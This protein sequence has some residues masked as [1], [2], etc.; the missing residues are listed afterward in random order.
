MF[1]AL[2]QF[3]LRSCFG[4]VPPRAICPGYSRP[5]KCALRL[6]LVPPRAFIVPGYLRTP[7]CYY[8]AALVITRCRAASTGQRL[9]VLNMSNPADAASP[10]LTP[11]VV[12]ASPPL[13]PQGDVD[14]HHRAV[15]IRI[16]N[17]TMGQKFFTTDT[18]PSPLPPPPP[19][20]LQQSPPPPAPPPFEYSFRAG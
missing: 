6:G 9:H 16:H 13:T 2:V 19:P 1:K 11:Q 14:A 8:A 7:K 3:L 12:A 18:A 17:P 4:I 15:Y 20:P 5:P 10:P